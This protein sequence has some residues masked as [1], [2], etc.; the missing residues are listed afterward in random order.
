MSKIKHCMLIA[1][2][3]LVST[4]GPALAQQKPS[5]DAWKPAFDPSG[6]KYKFRIA[7]AAVNRLN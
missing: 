3:V 5:L 4:A 2:L 7:E 6:A 1:F